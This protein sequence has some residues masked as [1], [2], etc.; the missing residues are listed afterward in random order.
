MVIDVFFGVTLYFLGLFFYFASFGAFFLQ[1]TQTYH[2]TS[3]NYSSCDSVGSQIKI[4]F[5]ILILVVVGFV[6]T[7][8]FETFE[9]LMK[10][11]IQS[12][13]EYQNLYQ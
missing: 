6:V 12:N 4:F 7:S 10:I 9:T 5:S 2:I 8:R 1:Q 11:F 13:F 3:K